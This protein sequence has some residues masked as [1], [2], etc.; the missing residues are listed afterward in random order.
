MKLQELKNSSISIWMK[1]VA[2][3][4]ILGLLGFVVYAG[5][6]NG[7]FWCSLG[8]HTSDD[9]K[10]LAYYS[11][12]IDGDK[13]NAKAYGWR[14]NQYLKLGRYEEALADFNQALSLEPDQLL[15]RM[16]RARTFQALYRYDEALAEFSALIERNSADKQ[17]YL[18]RA[19][20]FIS[21]GNYNQAIADCTT[22]LEKDA[23]HVE[24]FMTRATAE[25]L[26]RKYDIAL[27]DATKAVEITPKVV[28]PY[29]TRAYLSLQMGQVDNA[30]A[31]VKKVYELDVQPELYFQLTLIYLLKNDLNTAEECAN[32]AIEL[33][34]SSAHSVKAAFYLV[35]KDP[36]KAFIESEQAIQSEKALGR[37]FLL[38]S[39]VLAQ[40][41]HYEEALAACKQAELR[42]P[43]K[44][45]VAWQKGRIHQ[46]M[47]N[48]TEAQA[49][50][51]QAGK[52]DPIF[53]GV[54]L[55]LSETVNQLLLMW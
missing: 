24:A 35:Q 36:E 48:R 16:N 53:T 25:G 19:L 14:G 2:A 6:A 34:V 55:N 17:L 27:E 46:K 1:I 4:L 45:V 31:D 29:L 38:H 54:E 20:C 28:Y 26:L 23:G 8:L 18:L 39:E 22:V 11:K 50:F 3:L 12:A 44:P 47:G 15:S 41:G 51:A 5:V 52:S 33:G 49:D 32:K 40:L 37:D 9:Q 21:Q 43:Q 30:L 13:Q 42:G 7:G 10:A